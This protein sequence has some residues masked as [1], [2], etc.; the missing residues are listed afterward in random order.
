MW[1]EVLPRGRDSGVQ[2]GKRGTRNRTHNHNQTNKLHTYKNTKPHN[3]TKTFKALRRRK[4]TKGEIPG[5]NRVTQHKENITHEKKGTTS[6]RTHKQ[7]QKNKLYA[8]TLNQT[9][10]L[11]HQKNQETKTKQLNNKQHTRK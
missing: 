1:G 9:T 7:N 11:I 6:N 3:L 4:Q 5:L 2:G 10:V 8:K